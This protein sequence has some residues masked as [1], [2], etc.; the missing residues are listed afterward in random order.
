MRNRPFDLE[1]WRGPEPKPMPTLYTI[2]FDD[3]LA[4]IYYTDEIAEGLN[5]YR[6]LLD[7]KERNGAQHWRT[8][9][10]KGLPE[11]HERTWVTVLDPEM[12]FW[13]VYEPN[14]EKVLAILRRNKVGGWWWP[15]GKEEEKRRI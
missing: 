9:E 11:G 14:L 2:R 13:A 1:K 8:V 3:W 15:S 10:V 12:E 5:L 6:A 4:R 7:M